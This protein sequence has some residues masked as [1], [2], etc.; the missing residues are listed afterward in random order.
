[1]TTNTEKEYR[2]ADLTY[3]VMT[4]HYKG[5]KRPWFLRYFLVNREYGEVMMGAHCLRPWEIEEYIEKGEAFICHKSTHNFH[6]KDSDATLDFY[7]KPFVS[8]RALSKLAPS[9]D[10]ARITILKQFDKMS[11]SGPGYPLVPWVTRDPQTN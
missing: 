9:C 3:H 2:P 7:E 6:G 10:R 11:R 1:M 8:I 4:L 5:R